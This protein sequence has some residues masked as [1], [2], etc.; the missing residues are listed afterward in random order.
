MDYDFTFVIDGT[1]VDDDEVVTILADQLDAML[2]RGAGVD[3]LRI[4][5]D[6]EDAVT[7]ARDAVIACKV[8][9]PSIRFRRIDPDL[10]GVHEIAK[11]ANRS[12]QNVNQWISG[13][14]H[15]DL[16]PFPKPEGVTGSTRVW[17]WTEVNDWL[18]QLDLA[19][20][21]ELPSR[22]EIVEIDYMLQNDHLRILRRVPV[23]L[24]APLDEM[25]VVLAAMWGNVTAPMKP[26]RSRIIP[27]YTGLCL[28]NRHWRASMDRIPEGLSCVSGLQMEAAIDGYVRLSG[29][30]MTSIVGD[31]S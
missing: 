30:P 2:F 16:S 22:P 25:H 1:D 4:T 8:R 27:V 18:R 9:V 29:M 26:T 3:L 20:D 12:R 28:E 19:D 6:G 24:V 5:G 31:G 13:E 15:A 21:L 17:L 7:A 10:V 14:R 23:G 11:R